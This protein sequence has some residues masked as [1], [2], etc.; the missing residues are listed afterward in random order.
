[1]FQFPSCPDYLFPADQIMCRDEIT[2]SSESLATSVNA[3]SIINKAE[4][5]SIK[6]GSVA[7]FM[8]LLLSRQ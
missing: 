4:A 5:M 8:S 1:M 7:A 3:Q 2:G 6:M